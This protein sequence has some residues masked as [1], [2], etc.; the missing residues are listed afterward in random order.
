MRALCP[1]HAPSPPR[2]VVASRDFQQAFVEINL[3]PEV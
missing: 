1:I 2:F 3:P